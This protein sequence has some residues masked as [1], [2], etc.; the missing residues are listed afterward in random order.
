[1]PD[2]EVLLETRSQGGTT[3]PLGRAWIYLRRSG[4]TTVLFTDAGGRIFQV[5]V[6]GDASHWWE[7]TVRF[8]VPSGTAVELFFSRGA[9]PIP[10]ARLGMTGLFTSHTVPTPPPP[11][12]ATV[13][14][15]NN[16]LAPTPTVTITLDDRKVSLTTP[17]EEL[18]LWPLL[19]ELPANDYGT[20]GL[21]Q[22]GA[23]W[24]S[25]TGS[26]TLNPREGTVAAASP[27]RPPVRALNVVAESDAAATGMTFQLMDTVGNLL[28]L[29]D[30]TNTATQV[31]S[32]V[33]ISTTASSASQAAFQASLVLDNAQAAFGPV[34]L[35]ITT[36]GRTPPAMDAFLLELCGVQIALVDDTVANANGSQAGPL[37]LENAGTGAT[38]AGDETLVA[39]FLHSPQADRPAISDQTR[40]RRMMTY[41]IGF[42]TRALDSTQPS[43]AANPQVAK[44]QMPMWMA[45]LEWVGLTQT[46]L[47]DLMLRR[48]KKDNNGVVNAGNPL[49]LAIAATWRLTLSW[50]G[51]DIDSPAGL[52]HISRPNQVYRYT[53]EFPFAA[54]DMTRVNLHFDDQGRLTDA[55]AG[56][57][58]A[59]TTAGTNSAV[60]DAY[61]PAPTAIAF[62][63]AVVSAPSASGQ[64]NTVANTRRL[65][66]FFVAG[67]QR[68][69][70]RQSGTNDS[71]AMV[72]EWQPLL[73]DVNGTE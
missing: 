9:R 66:Q 36:S 17:S 67:P 6:S 56:G 16:T 3:S 27:H 60:P 54:P 13:N 38:L 28:N 24:T 51:P 72:L 48:Y 33:G 26:G 1:M 69:W 15:G 62:P 42:A 35:L 64:P 34:M 32:V 37:R 23:A 31:T 70:G 30:P 5:A 71:A 59:L 25:A 10:D 52:P 14:P 8:T 11:P 47:Q 61:S 19:F 43:S 45:E 22:G 21:T 7:Y 49:T 68:K 12:P 2:T 39:D 44:P 18:T 73:V 4:A 41:R 46:Q 55:N 53:A 58:L 65:P 40:I 50:D 63:V 20:D 29:R 57:Q